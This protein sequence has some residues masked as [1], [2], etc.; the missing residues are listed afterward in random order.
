MTDVGPDRPDRPE[1]SA[2]GRDPVDDLVDVVLGVSG[3][4][5]LHG[6]VFGEV[7][8]YLPGRRVTGIRSRGEDVDVH[9]V[10][11]WG[12]PV[13]AT[14]DRVREAL[15]PHV[16]GLVHVTVEDM[17]APPRTGGSAGEGTRSPQ[18]PGGA[19]G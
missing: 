14:A 10:L 17:M 3:V 9:L 12:Q 4:E 8:T 16:R 2:A 6:G 13:L 7:A 5:G 19:D 11:A 1:P 18:R 15:R